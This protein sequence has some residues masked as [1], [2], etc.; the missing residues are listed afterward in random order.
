M[1]HEFAA[2]DL[3]SN[4]FHLLVAE[5]GIPIKIKHRQKEMVRL[6]TG[7]AINNQ[8]ET[9]AWERAIACLARIRERIQTLPDEH[10]RVV[11]TDA[12]RRAE[13][14]R[15]FVVKAELAL[16]FPIEIITGLEEARLI[17]KGVEHT[18]SEN[19][20]RRLVIDIGGG[21]TEIIVGDASKLLDLE[22][23][24][25]GCV[26]F[27][28]KFFTNGLITESGM[29]AAE[30]AANTALK[31]CL[32]QLTNLHA[33]DFVGSSGTARAAARVVV[34]AGWCEEDITRNAIHRLRDHLVMDGHSE[35]IKLEGLTKERRPVFAGGVAILC[36]LFD[37][38]NIDHLRVSDGALREGVLL[39]LI[40]QKTQA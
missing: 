9:S 3:G 4:S 34:S 36:A 32:S 6:G 35:R 31:S 27:T 26:G 28:E 22:S 13:N 10:V 16:G 23:L 17:Y 14:S 12:M 15:A 24:E 33:Y 29:D 2:V 25:M 18:T 39:E 1:T 8:I 7:I 21:S 11:G 37:Q 38:L 5:S 20:G 40:E 30:A 19:L